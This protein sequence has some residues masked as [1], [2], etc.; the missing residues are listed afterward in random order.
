MNEGTDGWTSESI[1]WMDGWMDGQKEVL[2]PMTSIADVRNNAEAASTLW[3]VLDVVQF[4]FDGDGLELR[5]CP[6]S[7]VGRAAYGH[8]HRARWWRHRGNC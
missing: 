4:L 3:T 7:A 8:S 2:F 1:G 6:V 5:I